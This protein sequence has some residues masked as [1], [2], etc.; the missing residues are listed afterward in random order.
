[1]RP[2]GRNGL[3]IPCGGV[4]FDI[5]RM[6]KVVLAGLVTAIAM[7]FSLVVALGVALIGAI[8][9]LYLRV[10]RKPVRGR[11]DGAPG[12]T[13]P[14]ARAGEVIDVTA[15]EVEVSRIER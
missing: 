6:L 14:A 12:A 2:G 9:Y 10:R 13:A 11:V 15:T 5:M 1:M 8:A 7:I 3:Q 4:T